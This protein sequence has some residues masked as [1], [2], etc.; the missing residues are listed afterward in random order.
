MLPQ[1]LTQPQN[2]SVKATVWNFICIFL[3]LKYKLFKYFK[4]SCD[5]FGEFVSETFHSGLPIRET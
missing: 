3:I 1:R 5:R 2:E 4:R